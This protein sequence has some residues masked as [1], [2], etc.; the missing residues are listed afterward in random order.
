MTFPEI[1]RKEF[2]KPLEF[3]YFLYLFFIIFV[4]DLTY[5]GSFMIFLLFL[6]FI[7]EKAGSGLKEIQIPDF[8]QW[9]FLIFWGL[10]EVT[11]SI[12]K[13]EAFFYYFVIIIIPFTIFVMFNNSKL[14]IK[15]L[16]SFFHMLFITGIILS[17]L[18]F[19]I[20]AQIG[21]DLKKRIPSIWS[22]YNL[23]AAYFMVLLMFLL[24]FIVNTT[25]KRKKL[26]Y[27][28]SFVIV[29]F[30][31]FMTQTRGIWLA[32]LI[33]MMYYI[34]RKPK[35]ILPIFLTILILTV[36]FYGVIMDR[37]TSVVNFGTDVSTLGRFQAWYAS[38]LLIKENFLFGYGF[39]SFRYFRDSV[40]TAFFVILPHPHNTYLT[41]ILD[42][43]FIGFVFYISFYVK[44][45]Y[46]SFK[47]RKMSTDPELN[48]FS[49]GLQLTFVGFIIAF[50]FEPYFTVLGAITYMLWIL[51]SIS[52]YLKNHFNNRTDLQ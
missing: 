34:L 43:G 19:F 23:V 20:S 35:L 41:L 18:S 42:I 47:M 29:L 7:I 8:L 25:N 22:H 2:D 26:F 33:G 32:T 1:L 52:F 51:I 36:L 16:T 50:I 37:F 45:F 13:S 38:V 21:F 27:I 15:D 14:S 12:V 44:A 4:F 48:K 17:I 40:I 5:L 11:Q 46:Y 24:S 10:F 9:I 6:F 49:D 31:L 39:D 28:I 30:G 3:K